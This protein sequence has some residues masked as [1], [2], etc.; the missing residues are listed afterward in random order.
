MH[1]IVFIAFLL[2]AYLCNYFAAVG[3]AKM[4]TVTYH[5][6]ICTYYQ[7]P[8]AYDP[9]WYNPLISADNKYK[10]YKG[11]TL[12]LKYLP[13]WIQFLARAK[14]GWSP[15]SDFWHW[16]KSKMVVWETLAGLSSLI[17]GVFLGSHLA[18]LAHVHFILL[19]PILSVY[20]LIQGTIWN[21]SFN[22]WYDRKLM[23][24]GYKK[25]WLWIKE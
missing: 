20:T 17:S 8:T 23:I 14:Q 9:Q 3:N 24:P 10:P 5:W 16:E 19:I 7:N 22:Y 13:K 4:D 1:L 25:S 2:F 6:T 12:A 18:H 21:L 15:L 11:S